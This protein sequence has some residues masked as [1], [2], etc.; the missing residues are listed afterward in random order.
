MPTFRTPVNRTL[1]VLGSTAAL[2]LTAGLTAGQASAASGFD[3]AN[4]ASYILTLRAG[5]VEPYTL[6]P[7]Y[8]PMDIGHSYV[9][10]THDLGAPEGRCESIGAGYWLGTELEEAVLGPGFAP[11]EQDGTAPLGY[12][13]PTISRTVR[14]DLNPPGQ[15]NPTDRTPAM[16]A[17]GNGPQ[18]QSSCESGEQGAATGDIVN[19]AGTRV[20][21]STTSAKVDRSTGRYTGTS[22]AYIT[23]IE[24]AGPLDTITSL[25]Q[26]TN[27]VDEKPVIT[28]R[29]SFYASEMG[30]AESGFSQKGFTVSGTNIP[31]DQLVEQF[32]DQAKAAGAALA[33]I[34]PMGFSLL[35]PQVRTSTNGGRYEIVAPVVQAI[36]GAHLRDGTAGEESGVR[37]GSTAFTGVY[38]GQI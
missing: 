14:P 17:N 24:G 35:A 15:E 32:N 29:I 20:A 38:G 16:S 26:V 37:F 27:E 2:V 7:R 31:A 33:T 3:F 22:R 25:M 10:L 6:I 30:G 19:A 18:W 21:G 11:P 36:G 13:N 4:E 9:D 12:R 5:A 28:Y 23:G 8:L 1:T 34:G